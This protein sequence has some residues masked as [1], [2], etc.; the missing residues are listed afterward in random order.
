MLLD[1]IASCAMAAELHMP[2]VPARLAVAVVALDWTAAVQAFGGELT[3][4][5]VEGL[6]QQAGE[7][8]QGRVGVDALANLL[9]QHVQQ[10][11]LFKIIKRCDPFPP[12]VICW[13]RHD[14][15]LLCAFNCL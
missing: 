2:C 3:D 13:L 12:L 15:A 7:Q 8:Q 11:N 1:I 10:N 4:A 5:Q 6:F 9:Q 14:L